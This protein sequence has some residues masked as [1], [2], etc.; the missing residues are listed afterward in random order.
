VGWKVSIGAERVGAY[1]QSHVDHASVHED[2][3][4]LVRALD[5]V[6]EN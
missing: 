6:L 1:V 5:A 4:S 2:L 3:V